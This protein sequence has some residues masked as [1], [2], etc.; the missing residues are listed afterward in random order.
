MEFKP[1]LSEDLKVIDTDIYN[2]GTYGLKEK[3]LK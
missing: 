1:I 2:E 3:I